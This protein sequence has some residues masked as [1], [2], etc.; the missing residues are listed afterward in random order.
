M[1]EFEKFLN[2]T[3]TFLW[4]TPTVIKTKSNTQ[5]GC[6]TRHATEKM[7][8]VLVDWMM[9]FLLTD[10][11][12][13]GELCDMTKKRKTSFR[14]GR[15]GDE[16]LPLLTDDIQTGG[17]CDKTNNKVTSVLAD[18]TLTSCPF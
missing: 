10:D 5:P 12:E 3:L 18:W 17:L 16:L 13:T 2:S 7:T 11:V 15:Q 9:K 4:Q 1:I 8:S 6:V 14:N